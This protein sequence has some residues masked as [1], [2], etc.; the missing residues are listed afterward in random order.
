MSRVILAIFVIGFWLFLPLPLMY[1]DVGGFSEVDKSDL[2]TIQTPN[3]GKLT[4]LFDLIQPF[5]VFIKM[6]FKLL[7]FS[8]PTVSIGI[9]YF[10]NFIQILSM[11]FLAFM[12]RGN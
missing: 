11:I 4:F 12:L 10:F 8:I 3:V 2:A 7:V 1:L 9:R 5:V 6:Y